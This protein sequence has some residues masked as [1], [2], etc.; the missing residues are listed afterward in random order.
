MIG[1][2]LIARR[3]V[4]R[5]RARLHAGQHGQPPRLAVLRPAEVDQARRDR[6]PRGRA[7][8]RQ[9]RR[10]DARRRAQRRDTSTRCTRSARTPAGR[11][12]RARSSTAASSARGTT[13]ATTVRRQARPGPDDVRPA[14]LR[15]PRRGRRRLGGTARDRHARPE[16]YLAPTASAAA[17]R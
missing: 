10:A 15:R 3:R 12:P 13:R 11:L 2:G 14:A 5:R 7:D 8:G 4:R 9:G 16:L 1:Y 17:A 6:D